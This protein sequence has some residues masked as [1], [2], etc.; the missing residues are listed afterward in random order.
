MR[1]YT[2]KAHKRHLPRTQAAKA[3]ARREKKMDDKKGN[4]QVTIA[5]VRQILEVNSALVPIMN[6]NEVVKLMAVYAEVLARITK[7]AEGKA[8][9]R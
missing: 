1:T 5:E 7:E 3:E 6:K 4:I 9:V 2:S 8:N